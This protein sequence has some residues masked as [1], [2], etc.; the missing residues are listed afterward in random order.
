MPLQQNLTRLK[1]ALESSEMGEVETHLLTLQK[2][3]YTTP[4]L[5]DMLLPEEIGLLVAAERKRC[6]TD[7]LAA[8]C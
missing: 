8:S 5:V 2:Q 3:L 6:T 7:M 1:Q 4:H